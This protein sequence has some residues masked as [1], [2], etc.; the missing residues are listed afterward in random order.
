MMTTTVFRRLKTLNFVLY[1]FVSA[2]LMKLKAGQ[3]YGRT[4]QTLS[5][6]GFRFTEKFYS[7]SAQLPFHSHDLSHFCFVLSG[8]YQ[9]KI[10]ARLFERQPAALV[11]YPP[12]I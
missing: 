4:S 12:D 9:E 5:A 8:I 10:S 2:L 1:Y 6:G 7:S 3:F 11:F